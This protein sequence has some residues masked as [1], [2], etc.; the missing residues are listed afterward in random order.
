MSKLL[1]G[2]NPAQREAVTH[3]LGPLLIIAGPGS[4]KTRTVVHSIAYAIE[5]GVPPDRILAFS[6]TVKASKELKNKVKDIGGENGNLVNISTFHKFC[7]K[8]LR[9]D[10][11][12]LGKGHSRN[13]KALEENDQR[14]IIMNLT[15]A[16]EQQV[17]V[18][19]EHM[20]SHQFPNSD[21]I[22]NFIKKCKAREISPLNSFTYAPDVDNSED[23]VK[24]YEGYEDYLKTK[25]WIDY[26]SQ[27]LFTDELFSNVPE[28]KTKWQDRF[29]L[30]FVDEYQ[31]TDQVQYQIINAL[32]EKHENLRVVGDDDQGIYGWRGADIQNILDFEKDYPNAKVISL[33]QNYRSTQSIV[34]TS[35]ALADFNPDH[36]EKELFTR[37]H[38]GEKVKYL[39]CENNEEE[40]ATIAAFIQ[41]SVDKGDWKPK[42]FA[43]LY[44][45]NNQARVFRAALSNL[46]IQYQIVNNSLDTD[47]TGVT[48]MTIHK[49]K[50]L[51]FPIVFV[52][53]ICKDLLPFYY[54]RDEKDWPEELRL[55][56]VAMTRAKNW[57]CLSS[58]ETEVG[59]QYGRGQSPFLRNNY[60]SPNLLESV[61]T[62]E[63]VSVP[64]KFPEI[65]GE[66]LEY[67]EPIPE[68]L[69]GNGMTVLGIDPGIQN[70]GWSITKKSPDGYTVLKYGTQTTT[71]WQNTLVQTKSTINK[72]IEAHCPDA[73][74]V[75]KIEIGRE[76]TREDWFH[77]VAGCVATIKSIAHQHGIECCLY[78][79][80][81]VKE[82]AT[83]KRNASKQ[84]VQK[85]VMRICNLNSIPE[86]HHSADA[87]AASLCYL[88]SYLNSSRFEGDKRKME[89]YNTGCDYIDKRQFDEAI[90]EF[91][92]ALY[93]DPIF[94]DAYV[95]MG[96]AHL[97]QNKIQAAENAAEK[98]LRLKDNFHTDTQKLLDAIRKY[99]FGCSFL[100]NSAWNIAIDN[101]KEAI[102]REPI[103]TEAHC[104]LSQA[105]LNAGQLEAA[106]NAAVEALKLRNDYPPAQKLLDDIKIKSHDI[107]K[108]H[109]YHEQY[110]QAII[111]LQRAVKID[112]HFKAA[113]LYLGRTHLKLGDLETAEKE[114]REALRV[115]SA[116]DFA[117]QLLGEIKRKYKEQGDVHQK[118][119]AY[120]E[121]LKSYKHAIRIDDRYKNAYNCLGIVYLKMKKYSKAIRA[122]Q[123][124]INID[125]NCHVVHTNLSIVYH[126]ISQFTKA[127]SS[128]KRAITIKSD[129]QVAHYYLASSY[130]KMENLPN[131]SET[132]LKAIGLDANDQNT[133]ELLKNIQNTYLKQGHDYFK[134][135]ELAAAEN[136]ARK[137][138][139]LDANY[140]PVSS[141]LSS[142]KE[143]YYKRGLLSF[144]QN[145]W[146]PAETC[147]KEALRID[148]NYQHASN[149]LKQTYYEQGI[150][151]IYNSRFVEGINTLKKANNIDP[152]CEKTH[153]NLGRAYFKL[154]RLKKAHL[155]VKQ[156]LSIRPYYLQASELLSEINHPRKWLKLGVANVRYFIHRILKRNQD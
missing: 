125:E 139:R 101:F 116:Y 23:Y 77:Y 146:I 74:A 88:R 126:N 26:E 97:A 4:G 68:K 99:R 21:E 39:H 38:D 8:V 105:Y 153:Y 20:Q 5:N 64:T 144:K 109:F 87:I 94:S 82:A 112:A 113:Y 49:S 86:P 36:R 40:A 56:Y 70:V 93:I 28:V 53:G 51:E 19:I 150:D 72:L 138:L 115:D 81:H 78:T 50:G 124:A 10:I 136:E 52:T 80:Q 16:E 46:E 73:I 45:T 42:D 147:A 37:N 27:Q 71:G 107:G 41:R 9:E 95:S 55:L 66:I 61:E 58:Y 75:E 127:I 69:L 123:Q 152:N 104:G 22:L 137:A 35:R 106:R 17:R 98:V 6:F 135:D 145:E 91:K 89:L 3:K 25:G 111:E 132:V 18:E 31:D 62:L 122:Y 2:L 34:E 130:F 13:F 1:N 156:A 32:V 100:K 96:R 119:N 30:V 103:F 84:E 121:A 143:K 131:A 102:N 15:R 140:E 142:I 149:L 151:H 79:P 134:Q 67:V 141:L 110:D 114:A 90:D 85:G 54:S 7:R 60:I 57:L 76:A 117:S 33:G 44:R 65:A 92:E 59:S 11:E 12:K 154:D 29:E 63:I 133:L 83:D 118:R 24:I 128:L 48:L 120:S 108:K 129:Y 43:L 155:S 148:R 14:R 47:T